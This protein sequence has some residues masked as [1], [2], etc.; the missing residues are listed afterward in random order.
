M[1]AQEFAG[2]GIPHA[3]EFYFVRSRIPAPTLERISEKILNS[4]IADYPGAGGVLKS[5][6]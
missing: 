6:G 2:Y 3:I 4:A 1:C 5:P